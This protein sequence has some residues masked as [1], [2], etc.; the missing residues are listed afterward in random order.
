MWT[1]LTAGLH[2]I[3]V[4]ISTGH[5]EDAESMLAVWLASEWNQ[6]FPI[7]GLTATFY[8]VAPETDVSTR[9][10]HVHPSLKQSVKSDQNIAWNSGKNNA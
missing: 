3:Y 1:P 7:A 9:I 5:R 6:N 10:S 8:S 4:C 2:L